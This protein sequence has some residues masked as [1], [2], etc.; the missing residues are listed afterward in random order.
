MKRLVVF[1][2]LII[3]VMS[4][5]ACTWFSRDTV[6]QPVDNDHDVVVDEFPI[7]ITDYAGREITLSQRPERVVSLAPS[8]TEIL[9][10]IGAGDL[11]VGID[12]ASDYPGEI[13]DLPRVGSVFG[14]DYEKILD[15][16]PDLVLTIGGML[17]SRER[18]EGLGLT[19][20][21]IQPAHFGEILESINLV[22]RMTGTSVG[23]VELTDS[24]QGEADRL[25]ET[26]S[27]VGEADRP[28]VFVETWDDPLSTVGPGGF[29][30]QLLEM[31]G[32]QNLAEDAGM[33]WFSIDEEI[34]LERD[35]EVILTFFAESRKALEEGRRSGWESVTAVSS[36]RIYTID[37]DILVRP[38]P[39][40][41]LG[42]WELARLLHPEL[43]D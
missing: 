7:T 12:D 21:V 37:S 26:L 5:S 16:E 30:H 43:V 11:L 10:A 1:L 35:P 39:R 6:D 40:I 34:V 18:L 28:L 19:V 9:F 42:L 25:A 2:S 32:G 8:N 29:I 3:M 22:G 20:V 27:G 33:E 4:F 36:G 13:S 31:A 41:V 15:L 14:L 23:A 17:E 38:G 24:L